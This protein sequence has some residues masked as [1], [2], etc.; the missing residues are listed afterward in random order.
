MYGICH[1]TIQNMKSILCSC[2]V[3]TG[4]Y[5]VCTCNEHIPE[6]SKECYSASDRTQ[7]CYITN[8]PYTHD[9]KKETIMPY[10]EPE[11]SGCQLSKEGDE[12]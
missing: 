10:D 11:T 2:T 3:C 5:Y 7:S 8:T 9:I 1:E 6:N 4:P 12:K